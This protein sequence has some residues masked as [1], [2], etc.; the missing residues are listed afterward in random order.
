MKQEFYTRDA[1]IVNFKTRFYS[2]RIA[3]GFANNF[4]SNNN[5]LKKLLGGTA[6]HKK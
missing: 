6:G 1:C 3:W 5:N 2:G 4:V